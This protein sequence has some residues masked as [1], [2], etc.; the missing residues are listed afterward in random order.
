MARSSLVIGGTR[1]LGP[2]LVA[3]LLARG[4]RVTVLNRGL[5]DDSLPRPVER[6]RAD[7]SDQ[8]ALAAALGSRSF[9]LVV[10]STL[11]SG[12]DAKA[13]ARL[14][15]GRCGRYVFW[16]TGQVYLVRTGPRPPFVEG[17]YQG[18]LMA[19]PAASQSVDHE[20]WVYGIG[21]REAEEALHDA[22]TR[23]RFPYVS[24]RM[25]MINSS[26]D[27]YRRLAGCVR[28]LLDGGPLLVPDD[29]DRLALRHVFGGD[30]VAATERASGSDVAAGT[31][32]NVAQD[33][34]LTLE[35]MLAIVAESLGRTP[36]LVRVP[37]ERL[38]SRGLL[39]GCAPWSGRWMSVLDNSLG[40]QVLGLRYTPVK[41]YLPPLVEAARSVPPEAI[42]GYERRAEELALAGA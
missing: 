1:N 39:P 6:L 9:D 41:D 3:A 35:E 7:R 24:L 15:G 18:P 21:K 26:R 37:R 29:Q 8:A 25:P 10:D 33:E 32:L 38:E 19:E 2:D 23:S 11:Y 30:V 22:W 42:P 28:R 13:V 4:D 12:A 17:D 16:S 31:C 20:N 34:T 40:K 36:R 5:T 27:H 14:L